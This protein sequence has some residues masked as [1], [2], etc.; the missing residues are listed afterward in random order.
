ML[1]KV[2]TKTD[3]GKIKGVV[4]RVS[5]ECGA[6]YIGETGRSLEV[7][8]KEHKRAVKCGEYQYMPALQD[9]AFSGEMLKI[10]DQEQGWHLRKPYSSEKHEP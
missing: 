6:T 10:L 2:K 7:R 3:K 9:I 8:L 4:Y 5:C 1:I